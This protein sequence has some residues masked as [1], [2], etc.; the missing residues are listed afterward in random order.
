M[1]LSDLAKIG[2]FILFAALSELEYF[3]SGSTVCHCFRIEGENI[4]E[5]IHWSQCNF[6]DEIKYLLQIN[7]LWVMSSS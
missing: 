1:S 7:N 4:H 3:K 6:Q 2:I 5:Q